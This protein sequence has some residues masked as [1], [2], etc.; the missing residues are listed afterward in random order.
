VKKFL[1][2]YEEKTCVIPGSAKEFKK[3]QDDNYT[4]FRVCL[5]TLNYDKGNKDEKYSS[6]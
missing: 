5:M 3:I 2:Q 6:F 1:D 4:L